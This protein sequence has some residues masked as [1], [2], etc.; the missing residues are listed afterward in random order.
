MRLKSIIMMI[1][2]SKES[3]KSNIVGQGH[4]IHLMVK[5]VKH[6]FFSIKVLSLKIISEKVLEL[7]KLTLRRLFKVQMLEDKCLFKSLMVSKNCQLTIIHLLKL[8]RI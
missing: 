6:L 5:K 8:V 2:S 4:K 7:I 3:K 1:K